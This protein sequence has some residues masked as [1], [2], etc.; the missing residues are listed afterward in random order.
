MA[1]PVQPENPTEPPPPPYNFINPP[2]AGLY[3]QPT[4]AP[5]HN[6]PTFAPAPV[7]VIRTPYLTRTPTLVQCPIC[8]QQ[9][10]TVVQREIGIGTWL[11]ALG[12]CFLGGF[13]LCFLLPFFLPVCQDS[14]HTCPSCCNLIGRRNLI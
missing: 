6:K 12:I 14:I 9:V 13:V 10:V 2:I 5:V 4:P 1:S 11:I 8:R 3:Q 7:G